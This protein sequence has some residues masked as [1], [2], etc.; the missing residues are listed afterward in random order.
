[1]AAT[2]AFE[3]SMHPRIVAPGGADLDRRPR[4]TG[5]SGRLRCHA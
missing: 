1:V 4:E 5:S 3:Q 2:R